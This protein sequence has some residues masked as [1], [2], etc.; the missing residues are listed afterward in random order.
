M[1]GRATVQ[2]RIS[3]RIA[4]NRASGCQRVELRQWPDDLWVGRDSRGGFALQGRLSREPMCRLSQA[5][6]LLRGVHGPELRDDAQLVPDAARRDQV[7][8]RARRR[9][10]QASPASAVSSN[11]GAGGNG[12]TAMSASDA[13]SRKDAS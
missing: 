7:P 2:P 1:R 9:R 11:A 10:I 13:V 3:S 4:P 5:R 12:V 8:A 6:H